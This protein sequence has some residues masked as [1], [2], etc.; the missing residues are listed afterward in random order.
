MAYKDFF[1]FTD[2]TDITD[3]GDTIKTTRQ[4]L[5]NDVFTSVASKYDLMNDAMSMGIHRLWKYNFVKDLPIYNDG[6]H[7]VDMA[8]G[9]G[10][11]SLLIKKHHQAM[12]TMADINAEMLEVGQKNLLDQGYVMDNAVITNAESTDFSDNQFSGYTIAFGLR[13]VSDIDQ[14]I[15]EA[16]RI[17]KQGGFFACLEFSMPS[18]EWLAKLYDLYSFNVIPFLGE[19]ITG[20]KQSYQY[21]VESIRKFPPPARLSFMLERAGFSNVLSTSYSQ[22]IVR[23]HKAFKI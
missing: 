20:D 7:I 5:V 17:I 6:S 14:T 23:V 12:V 18:I 9:T 10:H 2:L 11:V 22:G 15:N 3:L 8:A 21:L 16:R 4:S 19:I 13:N 1:G